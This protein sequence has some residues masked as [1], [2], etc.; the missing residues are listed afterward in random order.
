MLYGANNWLQMP[1]GKWLHMYCQ[2]Y[3]HVASIQDLYVTKQVSVPEIM[4]SGL[5][6][7]LPP[8][9]VPSP[10]P[11]NEAHHVGWSRYWMYRQTKE[12]AQCPSV[13]IK[14]LSTQLQHLSLASGSGTWSIHQS[15]Y[16][17][18]WLQ[19]QWEPSSRHQVNTL[20]EWSIKQAM[21]H[22]TLCM[23][24]MIVHALIRVSVLDSCP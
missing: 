19:C 10:W 14:M 8:H 22:G 3:T 18:S 23:I 4:S 7:P 12:C 9:C 24:D 2:L 5:S 6:W 17:S 20:L 16:E 1:W 21:T 11:P 15:A 13:Q